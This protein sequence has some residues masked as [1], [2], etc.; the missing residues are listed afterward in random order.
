[1]TSHNLPRPSPTSFTRT[2]YS[3]PFNKFHTLSKS[4]FCNPNKDNGIH[5]LPE[6]KGGIPLE[7]ESKAK[8]SLATAADPLVASSSAN[9][10]A[11]T[12]LRPPRPTPSSTRKSLETIFPTTHL[13]L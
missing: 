6:N 11:A 13:S 12:C 1:M 3:H 2:D 5:T 7:S 9:H 10:W 4:A 8:P